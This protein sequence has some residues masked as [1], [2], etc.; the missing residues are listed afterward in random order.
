MNEENFPQQQEDRSVAKSRLLAKIHR[1]KTLVISKW[2][3]L[4]LGPVLGLA[5]IFIFSRIGPASY[6]S[7][8][9]MIVSMKLNIPEGSVYA[10]EMSSFL[11]TQAALM[12]SGAVLNRAYARVAAQNPN[13]TPQPVQIKVSVQPK[14]SIFILQA[15]G[16]D[17][18]YT[19]DYL[20]ACMEEYIALKKEMRTQTSDT[21]VAGLT[22]ELL[23]LEKEL[24]DSDQE[25]A[26]FQT[27]N[28]VVVLQE[29]GNSAGSYLAALNQRLAA[30]KSE[31][32]LLQTLT[33][34]QNLERQPQLTAAVDSKD[35]S[36][37]TPSQST[38]AD[39]TKA[40]Q[41]ILVLKAELGD[42]GQFLKPRHPKMI[43]LNEEIA[44]RERLLDIY[45]QQSAEELETRKKSLA[46]QIQNTEKDVKEWD[47]KNLDISR[48]SAEYQR[49]KANG[50]RIQ[51]LYDRLLQ[52]M[53][54]LDVNKEISPESVTIMEKASA[55]IPDRIKS[56]KQLV[57]GI[58]GGLGLSFLVLMILN[59]LDDTMN[60]FTELQ[61]LFDEPVLGQVPRE[62][63]I[64]KGQEVKLLEAN[65]ERYSFVEAYRN[66]RSSLLFAAESGARRPKTLLLTSSVPN[67]G[68]SL[69]SANLAITLACAGSRVLL[70]DAD[71]RKGALHRHFGVEARPGLT[72][73]L[74]E[75]LPWE[76]MVQPT[77]QANLFF[78]PRG[79][80]THKS[81][82][83]FVG[84]VTKTFLQQTAAKYDYVVVDTAPV[85]AADDVT[86]LAPSIDAV[87]FVIRAE[88]T[89]A[90]IA[91]AALDLLYHRQVRVLGLIFNAVGPTSMDY[92]YY[93]KYRDYYNTYPSTDSAHKTEH[94]RN[95]KV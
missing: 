42:L 29:Q 13:V 22:E 95:V 24:R 47:A 19:S 3:V 52:T 50:Q 27:S 38:D 28:S 92:Y 58:F 48:K 63:A 35:N 34:D 8:G 84:D 25:L 23:R 10:E 12:Q 83:F 40:K 71:L 68:K 6:V 55:G 93:Y 72:E 16:A 81:S 79:S 64:K 76:E 32:D 74:A 21:T 33:L 9:R 62:R 65:D 11:G 49:L 94:R 89:S 53:Q 43:A 90:R 66:L 26:D 4:V 17:P 7:Y 45:R 69:T 75:G 31:Y 30:L 37:V 87:L 61:E 88:H 1:Y 5:T 2:W 46:L 39:Y 54:T 59:R 20:E 91:R 44:R 67:D 60:S 57:I 78:L 18:Q 77:A 15:S 86:S 73:A 14:T 36:A 85:M 56:S 70:V 80:I 82:E 41:D 51:A